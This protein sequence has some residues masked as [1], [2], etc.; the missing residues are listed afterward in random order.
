M[1]GSDF[2]LS[3]LTAFVRGRSGLVRIALSTLST[4]L[5]VNTNSWAIFFFARLEDNVHEGET[6]EV[7][8]LSTASLYR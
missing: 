2:C 1:F 6:L 5:P 8:H 4:V 3:S 7:F